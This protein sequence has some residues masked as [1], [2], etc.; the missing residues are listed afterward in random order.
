MPSTI[1]FK[2]DAI[3]KMG[4]ECDEFR[5]IINQFKTAIRTGKAFEI[6]ELGDCVQ[7]LFAIT[8]VWLAQLAEQGLRRLSRYGQALAGLVGADRFFAVGAD[9]RRHCRLCQTLWW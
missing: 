2:S 3:P 9:Q 7:N 6:L 4:L 1:V 8:P 5:K